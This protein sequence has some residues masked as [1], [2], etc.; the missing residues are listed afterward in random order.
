M[1]LSTTLYAHADFNSRQLA[2]TT[3]TNGYVL[4][5]NG[6]TNTWVSTSS[7][8]ISGGASASG[9]IRSSFAGQVPVYTAATTLSGSANIGVNS[10]FFMGSGS[11]N[12]TVTGTN[13]IGFGKNSL[14]PLTNGSSNTCVGTNSCSGLTTGGNNISIGNGAMASVTTGKYNIYIGDDVSS[15]TQ[16]DSLDIGQTIYGINLPED[17][18]GTGPS[19]GKIGINTMTP[20]APLTV[21]GTTTADCFA[22]NS[23][24]GTC[25]S[26]GGGSG[27]VTTITAGTGITL[28]S[29]ATCTITCTINATSTTLFATTV[30]WAD[31]NRTDTYTANGSIQYP[32]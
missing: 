31:L 3:L 4:Q 16:R 17:R 1:L 10:N 32:Y 29:G 18:D 25:I 28:S 27:T 13:N 11:G 30:I 12:S 7:L 20:I 9:T 24:P 26:G 21:I 14:N 6:S 15:T 2:S 23:S 5:T 22:L 8:G 19:T